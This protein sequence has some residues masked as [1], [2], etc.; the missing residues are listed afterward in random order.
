MAEMK[1]VE[2]EDFI[3]MEM[4]GG[5]RLEMV[6]VAGEQMTV[7]GD[8]GM[9]VQGGKG[10]VR[11][12]EAV[13]KEALKRVQRNG[14]S[15]KGR[16]QA[17]IRNGVGKEEARL[18]SKGQVRG[19]GQA[20]RLGREEGHFG[21]A[22]GTIFLVSKVFVVGVKGSIVHE[23]AEEA[24]LRPIVLNALSFLVIIGVRGCYVGCGDI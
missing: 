14:E 3:G 11:K 6:F 22:G 18:I 5:K 7:E 2:E 15:Q 20:R 9:Q 19:E 4:K 16:I 10:A 24:G 17:G 23:G 13:E 12:I 1:E 21:G 8:V